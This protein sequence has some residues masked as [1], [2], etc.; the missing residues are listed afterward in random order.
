[1]L[2]LSPEWQCPSTEGNSRHW[3]QPDKVIHPL[4]PQYQIKHK[5]NKTRFWVTA[6]PPYQVPKSVGAKAISGTS[7]PCSRHHWLYLP[8]SKLTVPISDQLHRLKVPQRIQFRLCV[9]TYR[10]LHGSAPSYLAEIIHPASSCAARHLWS[11]DTSALLVPSTRRST[12][13]DRAFPAAAARAWNSLP[14]HVRNAPTLVAFRQELKTVLFR[15]CFPVNWL[16]DMSCSLRNV[17]LTL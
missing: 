15:E 2:Y 7:S 5:C 11:A 4:Q 13:G 14:A 8:T 16:P 10:C 17:T 12:L 3:L 9:L 1:M 6:M